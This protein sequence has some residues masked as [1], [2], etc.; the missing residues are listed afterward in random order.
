MPETFRSDEFD[1]LMED[2]TLNAALAEFQLEFDDPLEPFNPIIFLFGFGPDLTL[3]EITDNRIVLLAEPRTLPFFGDEGVYT[4]TVEG[5]GFS[6]G[7]EGDIDQAIMEG[8][9]EGTIQS[10]SIDYFEDGEVGTRILDLAMSG[11]A[12]NAVSADQTIDVTG[13]LPN[14]VDQF[15]DLLFA[16]AEFIDS[17][18]DGF[19]DPDFEADYSIIEDAFSDYSIST[20]TLGNAGDQILNMMFNDDG[21]VIEIA[22]YRIEL[23]EA[24]VNLERLFDVSGDFGDDDD[25]IWPLLSIFD[26]QGDPVP[27][28][29]PTGFITQIGIDDVYNLNFTV[30]SDGTGTYYLQVS[31]D[32]DAPVTTGFYQLLE[33]GLPFAQDPPVAGDYERRFED[34]GNAPASVDT[35]YTL[36]IREGGTG[37]PVGD[38]LGQISPEGDAD[39]VRV[40]IEEEGS[41]AFRAIGIPETID[42]S[43]T[44][45]AILSLFD[46]TCVNVFNSAGVLIASADE[47]GPLFDVP[48]GPGDPADDDDDDDDDDDVVPTFPDLPLGPA[49]NVGD[50]HLFTLDGVGY[51][52]HA[53]GEYVMTR[54]TDGSDFEVQARMAPVGENVSANIAAAVQLDGGQVM[55]DSEADNP[56]LINGEAVEVEGLGVIEVGDDLVYYDTSASLYMMVHTRD[57]DMDTGYSAVQVF[58]G[59]AWV[60][61]VVGLEEYWQGQVEGLLGNFDGDPATDIALPDGTVLERPLRF[62]DLYGD[63]RE[64]WRV[65]DEEQSL[66]TYG[67]GEGPDSFYLPDYPT[68][69][70][71]VSDFSDDE[72]AAAA[73][74]LEGSGLEPGTLAHDNALLD[75]LLTDDDRFIDS[76]RTAQEQI[77]NRPE[78]AP[79]PV[80]P[81]VDG[82]GLEGLLVLSGQIADQSGNPLDGVTVTFQPAGRSVQ[83]TRETRDGDAFSFD[84]SEGA[85]GQLQAVRSYTPEDASITAADALDV[86]RIAVG[87]EPSFGPAQA[88]N[89]IAADIDGDGRVTA[90]DALD[91]LRNA[92]G[93]SAENAPRWVFFDADTD[94]EGLGL[95]ASNTQV[96]DGLTID[97]LS[98]DTGVGL[99]GILI[100]SM[101]EVV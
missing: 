73:A 9:A 54:A 61:I 58:A 57:G 38:F 91:V 10:V 67:P 42:D 25:L 101:S 94:W 77:E 6:L 52:F 55:I 30:T 63:Y 13:I 36:P 5:T 24:R 35:P 40:D 43:L 46:F 45:E 82:G 97:A 89:Y 72:V 66:F 68:S 50:P 87:L 100:G 12:Y 22:E 17:V 60:D 98:A 56:L 53:A 27:V 41:Y 23:C 15:V 64:G 39:W 34:A 95:S 65:L 3:E 92:V 4:I 14:Q 69:M 78:E 62:E 80:V 18:I 99:T 21:L 47:A 2:G 93:L 84:L 29:S 79:A 96:P 49:W 44:L 32:P 7:N 33:G 8:T 74:R 75:L 85:T 48:A 19:D 20:I 11:T 16:G 90:G 37:D 83:L 70:I 88:Q 71:T 26:D 51:D 1:Q 31:A 81:E 59:P 28:F 86:L 76:G